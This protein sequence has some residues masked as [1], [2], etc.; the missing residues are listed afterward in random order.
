MNLSSGVARRTRII[1]GLRKSLCVIASYVFPVW[2]GRR[3]N[4]KLRKI[5]TPYNEP[6]EDELSKYSVIK[7][8]GEPEDVKTEW[9]IDI[10]HEERERMKGFEEKAKIN[11]IGATVTVTLILSASKFIRTIINSHA[12][13]FINIGLIALFAFAVMWM[14][15]AAIISIKVIT[16]DNTFFQVSM[17]ILTEANGNDKKKEYDLCIEM[18]RVQNLIRNNGIYTSYACVRNA[19][20]CLLALLGFI[21]IDIIV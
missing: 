21:I 2:W 15:F 9:L 19:L 3:G 10:Y 14:A 1:I 20:I 18:N 11:I 16:D 12:M 4:I 6:D 8:I 17:K 5:I 13:I 7:E